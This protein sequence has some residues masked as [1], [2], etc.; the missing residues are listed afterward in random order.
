M[1][2]L[3]LQSTLLKTALAG[4]LGAAAVIS[5]PGQAQAA[6]PITISS[7]P[8]AG[9]YSI[10][11]VTGKYADVAATVTDP[12]KSLWWNDANLAST[13]A[14]ALGSSN[15]VPGNLP[16]LNGNFTDD[17]SHAFMAAGPLFATMTGSIFGQP[18]ITGQASS[19][20]YNASANFILAQANMTS[21][22]WAIA[23]KAPLPGSG[24]PA[25]LPVF[26]AAAAFGFSRRLR[27]R[28][29]KSA[30]A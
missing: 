17:A 18:I 29:N 26:G 22:N 20:P 25:P 3:P 14:V 4:V 12:T 1:K 11:F 5:A 28:I 24:V 13:L 15:S 8:N 27:S 6:N 2:T 21:F 10:N 7:G 16:M 19:S 9:I 23:T 30:I